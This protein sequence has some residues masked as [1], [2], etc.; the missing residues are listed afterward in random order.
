MMGW[1]SYGSDSLFVN[2]LASNA[3]EAEAVQNRRL[4]AAHLREGGI[5]MERAVNCVSK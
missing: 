2:G 1:G 4:E 5:D 3:H